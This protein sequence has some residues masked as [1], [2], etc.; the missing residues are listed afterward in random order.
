[1]SKL[2]HSKPRKCYCSTF[3]TN[4]LVT[5][6]KMHHVN[7]HIY[8]VSSKFRLVVRLQKQKFFRVSVGAKYDDK[9]DG[10]GAGNPAIA[11]ED[12]HLIA[13]HCNRQIHSKHMTIHCSGQITD[14]TQ[15]ARPK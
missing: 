7:R 11:G 4:A 12:I 6:I 3:S 8:L 15:G 14:I 5:E 13:N 9:D 10:V 2:T 1:M